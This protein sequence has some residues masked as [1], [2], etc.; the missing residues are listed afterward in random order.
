MSARILV[1]DDIEANVRL[2]EAKLT[3]EYYDVSHA[4]DGVTALAMAA[5]QR[6]DIILLDV[7]MPG[8]DGFA[9]CRRLKD[10]PATRHIPVVLVTALDGRA[11]RIAGLEAGADDFL[12]KPIDDALLMAR[13]RSLTRLKLVIDELRQREASGR[14]IGV[15][16]GAAARLGGTG[17]RVL[18]VDDNERQAQRLI[19]DLTIDHRPVWERDVEK[20][21]VASRG[22]VDLVL[23]NA[24]AKTFDGLRFAAAMRSDE[25]TRHIPVITIVD[26]DDRSRL[27]K[28]LEIGVNDIL[29]KPIDP[30]ELA[31][32][33]RTQ[34][35][36]KRYTDFLRD[37]LDHSLELAVTDQLTGLHNRRYMVG[38]LG[39]LVT[40]AVRGGEPVAAMMIDIDHF[41]QINDTFGHDVGDE[42][43]REFAV[44]LASNVRAIDLPCRYG[45]EEF[46]VIMPD[47]RIEDAERIAERIRTHVAGSPFRVAGGTELL[48]ATISIGVAATLDESDTPEALLKRADS[49]VYEAKASGRNRVIARTS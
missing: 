1:V 46:T 32:R 11:D 27:V 35:K 30:Q 22:P 14:R 7:M 5:E 10:D 24:T 17:G 23:V 15:I 20:A 39:A 18:I 12:T 38:Q 42:V 16:A 44:R 40:R 41:K 48:T 49:A 34:I 47:T 3:A 29:A 25:A 26:P 28:A 2:L 13:V 33:A 36:R 21:Q 37:N 4:Y 9:V 43:L 6:P 45:G 31:A 8:M 19:D